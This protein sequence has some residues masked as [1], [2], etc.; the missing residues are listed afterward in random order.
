MI[1]NVNPY[2]VKTK[3]NGLHVCLPKT[4]S[5]VSLRHPAIFPFQVAEANYVYSGYEENV[6]LSAFENT[7]GAHTVLT[8]DDLSVTVEWE[9]GMSAP[10]VR[11]MPYVT[12]SYPQIT[13]DLSFGS[14]ILSVTGG[15]G[16]HEVKT[17]NGQ[18]WVI[19]TQ[20]GIK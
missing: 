5:K 4:V 12:I 15:N 3:G 13:P 20:H 2:I 19:Y 10:L 11:G 8:Y 16:R 9:N 7:G 18:T 14:T 17:E 1:N 6:I